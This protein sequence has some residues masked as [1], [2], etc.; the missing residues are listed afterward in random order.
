MGESLGFGRPGGDLRF[1][2]ELLAQ[3]GLGEDES[4][5]VLDLGARTVLL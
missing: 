3:L 2:P 5:R 4:L 1:P